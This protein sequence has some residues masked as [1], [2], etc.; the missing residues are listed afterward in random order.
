MGKQLTNV[1]LELRSA[2]RVVSLNMGYNLLARLDATFFRMPVLRELNL[3]QNDLTEISAE[4]RYLTLLEVLSVK[5]NKIERISYHFCELTGLRELSLSENKLTQLPNFFGNLHKLRHLWLSN[6]Q[7]KFLPIDER[8]KLLEFDPN[9]GERY[10]RDSPG[11]GGLT[12]LEELWLD[13]NDLIEINGEIGRCSSLKYMNL[14]RNKLSSLPPMTTNLKNLEQVVLTHNFFTDFP[15]QLTCLPKLHTLQLDNNAIERI[16]DALVD[17]TALTDL[18]VANN[19]LKEVPSVLSIMHHLITFNATNAVPDSRGVAISR[20][21]SRQHAH[22]DSFPK[23]LQEASGSVSKPN[24]VFVYRSKNLPA[25]SCGKLYADSRPQS[26]ISNLYDGLPSAPTSR[27][28]TSGVGFRASGVSAGGA[29]GISTGGGL[30]GVGIGNSVDGDEGLSGVDKREVGAGRSGPKSGDVLM[31]GETLKEFKGDSRMLLIARN[32]V[33]DTRLMTPLLFASHLIEQE[34][35]ETRLQR[36]EERWKNAKSE[37][38]RPSSTACMF[39]PVDYWFVCVCARARVC[40]CVG[41]VCAC[42]YAVFV[43][44]LLSTEITY[45]DPESNSVFRPMTMMTPGGRLPDKRACAY[46]PPPTRC[47][48]VCVVCKYVSTQMHYTLT[49]FSLT[50]THTFS[51]SRYFNMLD[52][53]Y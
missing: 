11:I 43:H 21:W 42:V 3:D 44:K 24:R 41:Y 5:N 1:P 4:F 6:N 10:E 15:L 9:T 20:I 29:R 28:S 32:E 19:P 45:R 31:P 53:S 33:R 35:A 51:L 27:P 22:S 16:P 25:T 7:I 46:Q 38:Q 48:R 23:L 18:N 12:S 49:I 40:V 13:C 14:R 8:V 30:E 17:A 39:R 47:M 2:P 36:G 52:L 50:S 26:S 34:E 37:Y